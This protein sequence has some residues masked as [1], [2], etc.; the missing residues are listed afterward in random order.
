MVKLGCGDPLQRCQLSHK[1][2]FLKYLSRIFHGLSPY[3]VVKRRSKAP[4]N[5]MW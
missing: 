4:Y 1:L 2:E 5:M 3:Q